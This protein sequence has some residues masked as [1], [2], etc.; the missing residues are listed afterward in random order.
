MCRLNLKILNMKQLSYFFLAGAMAVPAI[1]SAE[2]RM[3]AVLTDGVILQRDQPVVI[4]GKADPGEK[5]DVKVAGRKGSTR[6][7]ADSTWRVTLKPVKAGGPY[8]LE[9]NDKKVN[10]VLFGDIYL[11]SG[12]SNMELPVRRV[13]D[14]FKDEVA[15]YSNDAIREFKTP[16]NYAFHGGRDDVAPAEWKKAV[17]GKSEDFGALVYF[18]AKELYERNGHVPVGVVNSSWG[19]SKIETWISEDAL[20]KYPVRINRLRLLEDDSWRES[21]GTAERRAAWLWQSIM[22]G[23]DPGYKGTMRW[24]SPEYD[25]SGWES[26]DL[27]STDWGRDNGKAVNG[28]HWLRKRVDV[29]VSKS[30]APAELRLGCIV[31]ADSVW[32]NGQFVGFTSYQYPPRIYKVS[33]GVLKEKD[34]VVTVRVV[35]NGGVPH[36]VT[37]KPHKFIFDDGSEVSL[38]GQWRHRTGSPMPQTPSVTDFFQSPSVLYNGLITPFVNMPFRGVVWYQGESDVDIRGEYTDLMTTL[39][40]DWRNTFSDSSLPFYI[41][42]LADFLH[43]SDKGGRGAWQEMRDA[44]KKAAEITPRTRWI[45]NGDIGE[46]NDIHPRDKKTPGK[47]VADAILDVAAGNDTK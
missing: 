41:V 27:L 18:M 7:E 45:K 15:A 12:Q 24:D 21:L 6:A 42:E 44:Q 34:N 20:E 37:D 5:V 46:W 14:F 35:S 4:W 23:N 16:K 25:D 13:L 43:P 9:V 39:I 22:D 2:V 11:C 3:P 1:M 17:P 30:G 32:V 47:R 33:T 29:P 8:T 19:G 10:D 38:E 40:G 28:S 36:F 31:D 26:Y